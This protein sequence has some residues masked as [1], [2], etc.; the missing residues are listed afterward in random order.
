MVNLLE[1]YLRYGSFSVIISIPFH[2][3]IS[4]SEASAVPVLLFYLQVM[5]VC[6]IELVDEIYVQIIEIMGDRIGV[7][8]K[9]VI[10]RAKDRVVT[11]TATPE[12]TRS[13]I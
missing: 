8:I 4:L 1:I 13:D 6:L 7:P 12:E 2:L 11:L 10:K 9:V 5:E 3:L